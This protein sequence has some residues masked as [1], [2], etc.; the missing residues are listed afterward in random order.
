MT[1]LKK[2]HDQAFCDRARRLADVHELQVVADILHISPSQ[3]TRMK[4]RGWK[5]L[6]EGRPERTRPDDFQDLQ[7][8]M[9]AA[10]LAKHYGAGT[11]TI[12][13]WA[14]QLRDQGLARP[15]WRG[16]NRRPQPIRGQPRPKS[17]AAMDDVERTRHFLAAAGGLPQ[18]D[19]TCIRNPAA[20]GRP[21][22]GA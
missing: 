4:E 1:R 18:K 19:G 8:T 6:K 2:R 9:T 16:D 10:Q 14:R 20:R 13:K 22:G 15:D 17:L 12:V 21:G 7:W 5:A 3:V 11:G